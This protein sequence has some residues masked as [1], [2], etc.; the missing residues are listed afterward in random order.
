MTALVGSDGSVL[1]L[2]LVL[3]MLTAG[4]GAALMV[5]TRHPRTTRRP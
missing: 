2:V 1:W 5:A 3:L 4:L